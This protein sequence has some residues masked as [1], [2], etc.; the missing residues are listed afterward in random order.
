M[1]HT[2]ELDVNVAGVVRACP[3]CGAHAYKTVFDSI[4]R[5][6]DCGLCFVTPLSPPDEPRESEEYFLNEYLPLHQSNLEASCAERRAHLEMIRHFAKL[7]ERPRLLDVGCALGL[8]L[9]VATAQGWEAAGV[10]PSDFAARYAAERSGCTVYPGMLQEAGFASQSFD[11]VTLMDVIEHVVRPRELLIE[12]HRVL[13]PGGVLFSVTPNFGSFFVH[14]YGRE[15][16]GV[17][18]SE[19]INCFEASTLRKLILNAG[20]SRM[21]TVTKDFYADNLNRLLRRKKAG[22]TSDLKGAFASGSSLRMFRAAVNKFL[23]HVPMGD[24]LI[25]LAQR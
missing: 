5:C 22:A 19:H 9:E 7:P 4:R 15:A 23:Q 6:T 25:A 3:S 18:P 21:K 8:M 16:Y 10:E 12:I 14:L 1:A 2:A 24:K 20:F 11:V 17:G 13:R